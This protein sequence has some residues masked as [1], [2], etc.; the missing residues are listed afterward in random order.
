MLLCCFTSTVADSWDQ[1]GQKFKDFGNGIANQAQNL[2]KGFESMGGSVP[3]GY[4]Y[5]F[6]VFNG[7]Q[8][9][10]TVRTRDAKKIMGARIDGDTKDSLLIHPGEDTGDRF[11]NVHLFFSID[12]DNCNFTEDHY[13]LGQQNDTTVYA[14][15]T[16]QDTSL[17]NQGEKVGEA[18]VTTDFS[19]MI[20]NGSPSEANIGILLNGKKVQI[21]VEPD[22]YNTLQSTS[23]LPLRPGSLFL[24]QT[25]IIL[26]KNGLGVKVTSGEGEQQTQQI[27]PSRYNYEILPS[28]QGI[29]T[30]IAPGNFRQP[31]NGKV[32]DITPMQVNIWNPPVA[33]PSD[34]S[35][36]IDIDLPSQPLW[37]MYTGQAISSAGTVIT[38]P[39][40]SVPSGKCLSLNLLRPP[41]NQ[42]LAELYMIRLTTTDP[43]KAAAFLGLLAKTKL[44]AN[45]VTVPQAVMTDQDKAKLLTTKLP[46]Q[47][48]TIKAGGVAGIILGS[49]LFSSYGLASAGPFYY[50]APAPSFAVGNVLSTFLQGL[51]PLTTDQQNAL[52]QNIKNWV[53]QYQ[54]DPVG[55]REDV[56]KYLIQN[57]VSQIITNNGAT[58][59]LNPQGLAFLTTIMYGPTSISRMPV[60]YQTASSTSG[61]APENWAA[62]A[63]TVT[64]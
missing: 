6:R 54:T 8:S 44:P 39:I 34:N 13:T 4:V 14:Y 57:G 3:A 62:T 22:T 15:H 10:L 56:E 36:S 29:E 7:T 30:G 47:V 32:R 21:P 24:N 63:D 48:G 23:V 27:Y 35:G 25:E 43:E 9:D 38:N 55:A 31:T 52:L 33:A 53:I 46:D 60:L 5:S 19:S 2:I 37:V 26:S 58:S 20:Y 40:A 61:T 49:D 28:G 64:L 42:G 59:S 50:S 45:D 11:S 16:Y 18:A 51:K 17:A 12:I 41:V 1:V